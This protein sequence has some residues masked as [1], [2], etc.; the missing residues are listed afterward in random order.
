M[1]AK[2]FLGIAVGFAAL[3]AAI[4]FLRDDW[5][6][7][8]NYFHLGNGIRGDQP[9]M[10]AVWSR[11]FESRGVRLLHA[12]GDI[13]FGVGAA[14]SRTFIGGS[15]V[16]VIQD[17]IEDTTFSYSIT[18]ADGLL[19]DSAADDY[20]ADS[21]WIEGLRGHKYNCS[22][23][24]SFVNVSA[25]NSTPSPPIVSFPEGSSMLEVAGWTVEV[26]SNFRPTR[27]HFGGEGSGND[28]SFLEIIG[29]EDCS[30]EIIDGCDPEVESG[31]SVPYT[32]PT[33][34]EALNLIEA[35]RPASDNG[36][37]LFTL[38]EYQMW[39]TQTQ[40][41]GAG[42]DLVYTPCPTT[43][44]SVDVTADLACR[45]H[46]HGAKYEAVGFFFKYAVRLECRVDLDLI[47]ATNNWKIHAVFGKKGIAKHW[48]CY[49][50]SVYDC[51]QTHGWSRPTYGKYCR[52]EHIHYGPYRYDNRTFYWGYNAKLTKC[53]GDIF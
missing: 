43:D 23:K 17:F 11:R 44:N 26:N 25:T 1:A 19:Q 9:S 53:T 2:Y 46:D 35:A 41:C 42:T 51:W 48:G 22:V 5:E 37:G 13:C 21:G 7:N 3:I 52:G 24:R 31:N 40:W 15:R 50:N 10:D 20:S 30:S 14:R 47:T 28:S 33:E 34:E 38:S 18:D 29:T 32:G 27:L 8:E 6:R 36:R 16:V 39:A 45:R 49:E 4:F 12:G